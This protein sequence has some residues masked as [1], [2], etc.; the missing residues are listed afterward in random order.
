ISHRPLFANNAKHPQVNTTPEMVVR[1]IIHRLGFRYR[2]HVHKLPG[3]PDI[4]L[5][6]LRKAIFVSMSSLDATSA[7]KSYRLLSPC[8]RRRRAGGCSHRQ[9]ASAEAAGG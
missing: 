4:V 7:M 8:G 1:P 9:A 5:P 2:L 3:T 6:R